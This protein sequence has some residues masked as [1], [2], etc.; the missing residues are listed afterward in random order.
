MYTQIDPND[1]DAVLWLQLA[2]TRLLRPVP[3]LHVGT[4][5][6]ITGKAL[7]MFQHQHSLPVTGE[8]DT[9]TLQK[10]QQQLDA[11]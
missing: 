11:D 10:I 6:P 2:L 5:S 8:A 3:M 9:A 1:R 4:L 7:R